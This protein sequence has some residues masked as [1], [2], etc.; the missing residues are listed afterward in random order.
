MASAA[1]PQS[2][3]ANSPR[4]AR[5]GAAIPRD[6]TQ[7]DVES[8]RSEWLGKQ[9]KHGSLTYAMIEE[10]AAGE[11]DVARRARATLALDRLCA[12]GERDCKKVHVIG[13]V[14]STDRKGSDVVLLSCRPW[15]IAEK[16]EKVTI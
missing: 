7:A 14:L 2:P 13:R 15:G 10:A 3:P 16:L 5:G 8:A 12:W 4:G 6:S 11:G 1:A 9:L